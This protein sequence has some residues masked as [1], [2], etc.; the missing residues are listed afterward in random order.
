MEGRIEDKEGRKVM[1]QRWATALQQNIT[2]SEVLIGEMRRP[3]SRHT[4]SFST[5]CGLRQATLIRIGVCSG[6]HF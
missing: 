6:P 4:L 5:P 1:G 3:Q 2:I